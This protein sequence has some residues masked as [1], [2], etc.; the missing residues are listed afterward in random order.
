MHY[1]LRPL[2]PVLVLS[3]ELNSH[4][5]STFILLFFTDGA[6]TPTSTFYRL[7]ATRLPTVNSRILKNEMK[8]NLKDFRVE[9]KS[10]K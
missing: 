10:C 7:F 9:E 3:D 2:F 1:I 8:K 6:P 5:N 4:W